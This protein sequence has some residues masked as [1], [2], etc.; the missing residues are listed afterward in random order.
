MHDLLRDF[1]GGAHVGVD[2]HVGLPVKLFAR[3]E[4]FAD[5]FLRIRIVEQGPVGLVLSPVPR[6]F[7][8]RPRGRQP[9]RGF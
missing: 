1:A 4:Q 3:G 8:A 9:G 5:F 2:Q 7:P 6:F